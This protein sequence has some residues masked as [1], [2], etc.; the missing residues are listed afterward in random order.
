MSASELL[1]ADDHLAACELCHARLR[2]DEQLYDS[3]VDAARAAD[4]HLS[5]ELMADYIDDRLSDL[6]R[7]IS[8]SHIQ[9]CPRCEVELSDLKSIRASMESSPAE[10]YAPRKLRGARKLWGLPA[11]RI[12]LEIA[13]MA[14]LAALAF[15]M[16]SIGL[17]S[18]NKDLRAQLDQLR[19]ANGELGQR[20]EEARDQLAALRQE[21]ERLQQQQPTDVTLADGGGMIVLDRQGNLAGPEPIIANQAVVKRTLA[22]ANVNVAQSLSELKGKTGRLMGGPSRSAYGLISPV[23]VVLVTDRPT[24]RWLAQPGATGY[25]VSLFDPES[26][27]VADSGLINATGWTA[28]RALERGVIYSWQ[29]RAIRDGKEIILPPPEAADARFK[30]LERAKA[31][32]LE[33]ALRSSPRSHLLLGI[34]YAE[35]G[36]VEEAEQQFRA[37]SLANPE[38]EVAKKLL[39]SIRKQS[40]RR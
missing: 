5:Y 26:K 2:A 6:D 35:A 24:F 33:R 36:L 19:Q 28:D 4:R 29:V 15:W 13:A 38:S 23:S 40:A 14:A 31:D 12:P 1:A 10:R 17:R 32:E 21:N 20:A 7:E 34:L 39:S 25:V 27:K 8:E 22:T 9:I 37:L 11:Y 30:V 3:V 16:A 18:E